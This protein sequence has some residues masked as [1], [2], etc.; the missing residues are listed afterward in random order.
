M[1]KGESLSADAKVGSIGRSGD[2]DRVLN[3]SRNR[4]PREATAYWR[5][6]SAESQKLLCAPQSAKCQ[7]GGPV[8]R[9]TI[10]TLMLLLCGL[11]AVAQQNYPSSQTPNSSNSGQT[12]VEGCLSRSE[13]GY[14]LTGKS[15]TT[16]KLSGDT[17]KLSAHVGHE[18]KIKGTVTE[19]SPTTGAP[20]ATSSSASE[21]NLDVTSFKHVS[22]TCTSKPTSESGKPPMSE[23]P[24]ISDK[25]PR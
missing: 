6:E 25:P 13:G 4:L 10:A 5:F 15:G 19:A 16:Y 3:T 14:T 20:S 22:E 12:T 9:L 11:W 24:P 18:M 7:K 21:P 23:K 2:R 1:F 8:N 17:S